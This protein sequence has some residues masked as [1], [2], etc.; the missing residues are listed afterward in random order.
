MKEKKL[1]YITPHLSTGGMPQYLLKQIEV[2]RGKFD[3]TVVEVANHSPHYVVQ[4]NRIKDLGISIITLSEDKSTLLDVVDDY[5]ILHFTEIPEHYL[6][7]KI[8]DEIFDNDKRTYDIVCSTHGSGTNPDRIKYHP[9]RYVL[10]SEWSRRQFEHLDIDTEVWEYP[11][12]DYKPN[13]TKEQKGLGL[14][15]E[16]KHV[17]MVG[18]FTPGKNQGEI[19]EV[20]RQLEDYKI[21]F[22]FVGNQAGNFKDYWEPL[23][24]DKPDNC[25]VWGERDDVDSFYQACDLFYFSSKLELNPLSIKEALSWNLP[26]LMRRLHTYL[27]TYDDNDL[28][29]YITDDRSKTKDILIK[30]LGLR[31]EDGY[32]Y[33]NISVVLS[34]AETE[35]RQKLLKNCINSITTPIILSSHY[36]VPEEIQKMTDWT[37]FERENP[38]LYKKDYKKYNVRYARW[39]LDEN[40][41]KK[42]EDMDFEHSF[43]VYK[44]VQSGVRYA[45]ALGKEVINVVNYDYELNSEILKEHEEYLDDY[46]IIFY[47][48]DPKKHPDYADASSTGF[49]TGKTEILSEFF[50]KYQTLEEYYGS[51]TGWSFFEVVVYNYFKNN[52]NIRVKELQF[53][54]LTKKVKTNQEG[55]LEF[56]K[57]WKDGKKKVKNKKI[58]RRTDIINTFIEKY[59]YKSYLE[60]GVSNGANFNGVNID[61]KESVD[62]A[63]GEYEHADPTYKM[64]SDEFFNKY[65]DKKYDIIFIDGLHHSDQVDKDI[66]NSV[67]ALN[68]NGSIVLHDC[69][70][71][72]EIHQR[73]PRESEYWNGDVWKSFVKFRH[74]N[75]SFDCYTVNTDTGCGV[76][77]PKRDLPEDLTYDWLVE[78]RNYAL[79]V[80]TPDEFKTRL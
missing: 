19:F 30:K 76:I 80:I 10:V 8:L 2:F 29:T 12:Y 73:V 17:L 5:D 23:M 16:Y 27:D 68:P 25:I 32:K 40:G 72:E 50:E 35:Y 63:K 69:N 67:K 34:Y 78:N 45:K 36:Q 54:D 51:S 39:Y 24:E 66:E 6:S 41:E 22:H 58:M 55:L 42:T 14:D 4:K 46:D 9:D 15:P 52:S 33:N 48:Y 75:P 11:V 49:F 53:D 74:N 59:E 62:P 56:S 3:I 77:R 31:N 57:E 47:K 1:L 38:L 28:V 13:Y 65:P 20:A 44:L 21:K 61:L 60:I 43:A 18:L 7:H 79:D 70:P 37:I 71:H 64:T 26:I